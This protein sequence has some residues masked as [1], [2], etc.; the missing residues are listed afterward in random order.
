MAAAIMHNPLGAMALRA[1]ANRLPKGSS[2]AQALH[3]R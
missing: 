2:V 1:M 3:S